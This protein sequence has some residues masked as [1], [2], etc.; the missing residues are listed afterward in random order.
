[1][2]PET[3]GEIEEPSK[4]TQGEETRGSQTPEDKDTQKT[5]EEE[6]KNKSPQRI[7]VTQGTKEGDISSGSDSEGASEAWATPKKPGRGRKF[8]KEER[9]QETYKDILKGAQPTIKQLIGVRQ[10]RKLTKASQGGHSPPPR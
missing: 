6:K 7:G 1:M 8:K 3:G 5:T 9:D 2:A 10:T 4:D